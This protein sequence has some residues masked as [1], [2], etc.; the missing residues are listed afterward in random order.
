MNK[1]TLE[2]IEKAHDVMQ[3]AYA[4][5][6][7]FTVGACLRTEDDQLFAGCN[8]ENVS[9]SL[10]LCAESCALG[11]LV[12]AGHRRIVEVV[13]ATKQEAICAPCGACRQRFTEF[14]DPDTKIYLC[15]NREIKQVITMADLLPMPFSFEKG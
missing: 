3:H 1:K 14:M 5:Y 12:S 4:P 7:N 8:I 15:S 9:Y 6:S 10:T 2:M 11:S 13:I